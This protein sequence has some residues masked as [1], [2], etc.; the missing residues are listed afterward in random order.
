MCLCGCSSHV[1]GCVGLK[2]LYELSGQ[3][4]SVGVRLP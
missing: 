1:S 2:F 3:V 4:H